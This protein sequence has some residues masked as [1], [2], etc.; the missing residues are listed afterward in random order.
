[1][2]IPAPTVGDVEAIARAY[3]DVGMRATLAPAVADKVFY[4]VVPGL[5]A[6]LPKELRKAVGSIQAAPTAEL[7][8][9]SAETIR[10]LHG[11]G[12]GRIHIALAPTIPTQCTDDFLEGC[13]RL[14]REHGWA[15]TRTWRS[16]RS[17]RSRRSARPQR[18]AHRRGHAASGR[19]RGRRRPQPREQTCGSA[20][21]SP[22]CARC[23][24]RA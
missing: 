3:G 24:T 18:L 23:W 22:P 21:A 7:F 15:C 17:R 14:A 11:S 10:R 6:L 5:M 16:R 19:C 1:M 13:A 12:N 4:E 9:L 20:V 2:A 8:R